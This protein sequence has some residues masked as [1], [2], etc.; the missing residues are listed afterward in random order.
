MR[1]T[2]NNYLAVKMQNIK[3]KYLTK[4]NIKNTINISPVQ[5][6]ERVSVHNPVYSY[7]GVDIE[8]GKGCMNLITGRSGIGKSTLLREYFP[9]YFEHYL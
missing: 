8:I 9:Q 4:Q 7:K 2:D 6:R 3:R 1:L 5:N